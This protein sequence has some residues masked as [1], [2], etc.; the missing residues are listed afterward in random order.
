M[1]VGWLTKTIIFG[2]LNLHRLFH[3]VGSVHVAVNEI[4]LEL[5]SQFIP[6]SGYVSL[7]CTGHVL[8]FM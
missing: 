6:I 4:S 5:H 1:S 3:L 2:L 7:F 8:A